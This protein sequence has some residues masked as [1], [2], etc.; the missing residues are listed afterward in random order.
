[1]EETLIKGDFKTTLLKVSTLEGLLPSTQANEPAWRPFAKA[2]PAGVPLNF[3]K[4][5][6]LVLKVLLYTSQ[7]L[8]SP[9]D[10]KPSINGAANGAQSVVKEIGPT[11]GNHP[12]AHE[13]LI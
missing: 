8:G 1:N 10:L 13:S 4:A 7:Q 9:P 11:A 5:R 12:A 2:P 3:Q 6:K